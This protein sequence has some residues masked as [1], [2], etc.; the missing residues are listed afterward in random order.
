MSRNLFP[1]RVDQVG[2]DFMI[3]WDEHTLAGVS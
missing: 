1:M 3:P 2:V